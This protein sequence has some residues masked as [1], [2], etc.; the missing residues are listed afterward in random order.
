VTPVPWKMAPRT[1]MAVTLAITLSLGIGLSWV[2]FQQTGVLLRA[3]ESLQWF[4][5]AR[6]ELSRGFLFVNL[7]GLPGSP[8]DRAQGLALLSQAEGSLNDFSE[9][10]NRDLPPS[11][12]LAGLVS[13][14]RDQSHALTDQLETRGNDIDLRVAYFQ[15]ERLTDQIENLT[16]GQLAE[17]S[18]RLDRDFLVTLILALGLVSGLGVILSTIARARDRAETRM[19]QAVKELGLAFW[20]R[21]MATQRTEVSPQWFTLLGLPVSPRAPTPQEW[22]VHMHPDDRGPFFQAVQEFLASDKIDFCRDYR[23]IHPDG[24][25]RWIQT[26][27]NLVRDPKGNAVQQFGCNRDVSDAK[28]LELERANLEAQVTQA[29][30]TEAIGQLAAGIAHDLNNLLVP[31]LAYSDLGL[32][33]AGT[34]PPAHYFTKIKDVAERAQ[35]LTRQI[36]A[37]SRRQVLEK[38]PVDLNEL[39]S[40]FEPMLRRL[41]REDIRF[42]LT[43]GSGLPTI[44]ADPGQVE[45]VLLNLVVNA[46]DAMPQ[47][48]VLGLGTAARE[49]DASFSATH[50]GAAVGRHAVL[51]VSDTGVGIAPEVQQKI[52]DPFFTTKPRGEGTGLGLSTVQG[53]VKQH[54]GHIGVYSEVGRGTVFQLYW[55]AEEGPATAQPTRV[56]TGDLKGAETL[57]VVEDELIVR[58]VVSESLESQGYRV[59]SAGSPEEALAVTEPYDLLVTDVIMPGSNGRELFE[60]LAT[61]RP[62]LRVLFMSG[63]TDRILSSLDCECPG[64]GFLQKPFAVDVLCRKVRDLLDQP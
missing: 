40:N 34:K 24:S 29:Q 55:P 35:A 14:Y 23:V 37:F 21:D 10:W 31:L 41:I 32:R 45:Q 15:L 28:R 8:Y 18:S 51:T 19:G 5:D 30:K 54:G 39:V 20:H 9:A 27:V 6:T 56:P 57:L 16:R 4:R 47:G 62:G 22:T 61:R 25:V 48:G 26:M 2:H 52:F 33:G 46:R 38:R 50:F 43:L 17:L 60:T 64:Q 1:W 49:L 3:T 58:E 7:A 63:Y 13:E 36:L 44:L 53:I 11:E 12:A 42:E 59:L